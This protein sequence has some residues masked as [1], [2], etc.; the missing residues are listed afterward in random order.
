M[1]RNCMKGDLLTCHCSRAKRPQTLNPKYSWGGCGDNIQ[2]AA[3]FTKSFMYEPVLNSLNGST[4][5]KAAAKILMDQ[6]NI[7]VGK[8]VL[9]LHIV[10][11]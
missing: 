6:H 11:F 1:A 9:F 7:E 10:P 5:A 2:Y 8:Q 4:D 3:D